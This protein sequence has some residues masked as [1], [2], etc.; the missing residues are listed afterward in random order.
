[1]ELTSSRLVSSASTDAIFTG[2]SAV[3]AISRLS[4]GLGADTFTIN[5]SLTHVIVSG[6]GNVDFG[7]GGRDVIDLSSVLF[8]SVSFNLIGIN[9]GTGIAYNPGN[10]TRLFDAITLN[11]GRQILFEGIDTIH[12]A[13]QTFSL[14]VVIPND[15]L[16]N[17]QW[18]L[19]MLNLPQA[20][21]FTQGASNVLIGVQDSGLGVS[22]TN[23]IHPD[24]RQ[25]INIP[26]DNYADDFFRNVW[27]ETF[28]AQTTSHGTAVTGIIAANSNNG[29]GM[30]GINWNSPVAVI[31][32]LD[33]NPN[34]QS[35]VQATQAMIAQANSQG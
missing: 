23:Q 31:D 11:D 1:M 4:G 34:D 30:S 22:A 32:V 6:N 15:P 17:Q 26:N 21:R 14:P 13:D 19:H 3:K 12:F 35:L 9:E 16:F 25:P 7:L 27:D 10:G 33:N 2:I 20:W 28:R 18:N 29:Q 8:S 5:A 24:L